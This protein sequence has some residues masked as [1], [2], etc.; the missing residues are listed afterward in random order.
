VA[1]TKKLI[2]DYSSFTSNNLPYLMNHIRS[3]TNTTI[4]STNNNNDKSFLSSGKNTQLSYHNLSSKNFAFDSP[5]ASN[6]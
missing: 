4:L 3:P 2:T 5:K 6:I 1:T